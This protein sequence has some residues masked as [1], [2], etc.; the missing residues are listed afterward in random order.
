VA[1]AGGLPFIALAL[2]TVEQTRSVLERTSAELGDRPWGVGVL[3]FAPEETRSAQLDVI[4]EIRP[5]CAIIAGGRPSQARALE[6]VASA[7][8]CTSR[9]RGCSGS[10]CRPRP[11]VHLR[12]SECGGHVGPRASFPLWEAQLAVLTDF[13]DGDGGG[14]ANAGIQVFFAGGCTM[15]APR[16]MVAV[17]AAPLTA[18]GARSVS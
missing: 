2:S 13:M 16:A 5:S 17:L 3:G 10:F 15:R 4:R 6:D 1:D 14:D 9:R 7:P 18:R 11:K 12:G 8:S